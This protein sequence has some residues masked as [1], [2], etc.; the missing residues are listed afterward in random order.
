MAINTKKLSKI[1]QNSHFSVQRPEWQT[2]A[3]R[4]DN[5]DLLRISLFY[6]SLEYAQIV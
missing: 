5:G 1:L 3:K 4:P 2:I 6:S